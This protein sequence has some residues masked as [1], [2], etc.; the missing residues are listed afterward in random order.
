LNVLGAFALALG[1]DEHALADDALPG[2]GT[3][4]A[5][6]LVTI[7]NFAPGAGLPVLATTLG[8]SHSGTVR[9][10]DRLVERDLAER[11]PDEDDARAVRVRLTPTGTAAVT[12]LR[13]ARQATLERWVAP[14]DAAERAT[15]SALVDRMLVARTGGRADALRTCRL[16]DPDVCGHPET[17]PVTQGADRAEGRR[18]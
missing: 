2:G 18:R 14:L 13:D 12:R 9:L 5:T 6:A 1:D 4:L 16:C 15:L 17:C 7:D 11:I 3:G 10:V 8:L